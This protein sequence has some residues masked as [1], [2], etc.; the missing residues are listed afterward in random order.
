M[1]GGCDD[2]KRLMLTTYLFLLM[3]LSRICI[4]LRVADLVG[5]LDSLSRLDRPDGLDRLGLVH[6]EST[7]RIE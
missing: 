1:L 3:G 7:L 5:G 2:A 6:S 4:T